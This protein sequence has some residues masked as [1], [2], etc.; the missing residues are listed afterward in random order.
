MS[1]L[2]RLCTCW[3]SFPTLTTNLDPGARGDDRRL[4]AAQRRRPVL[5]PPNPL[6][7]WTVADGWEPL[8]DRLGLPVPDEA[9]PWT[10]TTEEFRAHNRLDAGPA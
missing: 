5:R 7:E 10:H 9:F 4:R 2:Q 8:C 6:L 1:E 3:D